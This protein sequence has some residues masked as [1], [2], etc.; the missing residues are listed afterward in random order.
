MVR[1][2]SMLKQGLLLIG[3]C[4]TFGLP[5]LFAQSPG[6]TVLPPSASGLSSADSS[7]SVTDSTYRQVIQ[8]GS[9]SMN[10]YLSYPQGSARVLE[11]F[12]DNAGELLRLDRFLRQVFRDSLIYVDSVRLC[13]YCSI[14]G[15]WDANDRLARSRALGFRSYLDG[16][17][18]LSS[19]YPV[20]VDWVAEDWDKLSEMVAASDMPSCNAVLA[21]IRDVDVFKGRERE[22]MDLEGGV[23][24]RYMLKEFFPALRRVE[25]TVNYDLHRIIEEKLKRKLSEEEFRRELER[26]RAA[27]EAEERRLAEEAARLEAERIAAQQARLEAERRA[28]EQAA[29]EREE[30]A[31]LEAERIAAEQAR[32][33]AERRAAEQARLE[34]E[35]AAAAAA[36]L[37]KREGRKLYPIIGVKTD[38]VAWSGFCSD[39]ERRAFMPN[40]E[41]EVYFGGRWSVAASALYADWKYD[42]GRHFWGI[43]SYSGEGRFWVRN[44]G[45]FR[46]FFF[47]VYGEAGD[48][49]LQRDRLD[50]VTTAD[51]YTGTY[52]S[53]GVAAGYFLPLSR[54]WGL[55]LA[56]RGGYRSADYDLYDRELPHFYY[57]DS[58]HK[59]G[60]A[61][62]G[63]RLN[64]VYRFGRGK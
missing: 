30:A 53:A 20:R 9:R 43:S 6:G 50:G 57:R 60:F 26:E 63:L 23:P 48:F 1:F 4:L 13:G 45:L 18:A 5:S 38:L 34:A 41:A 16:K 49:N 15:S 3:S 59:N 22:L 46:G 64:I 12:G 51:N 62:T 11:G 61:L 7:L 17:Y 39:F 24:Y 37:Q 10:C 54:H 32:L 44:D 14:E 36:R 25:I 27:A 40:L 29:R 55:E 2:F 19:R 52:W 8:E 42:G 56:L 58:D 21:L 31:R 47:G 33:E 28:A 35:R